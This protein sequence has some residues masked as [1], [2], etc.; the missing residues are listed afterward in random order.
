[1]LE[2]VI[3]R[4]GSLRATLCCALKHFCVG[5]C[6]TNT[7]CRPAAA[8][9][10]DLLS[11]LSL[12]PPL[13][14]YSSHGSSSRTHLG[15]GNRW[16]HRR[17]AARSSW[18]ATHPRRAR[19]VSPDRRPNSRHQRNRQEAHRKVGDGEVDPRSLHGGEGYT[20][21]RHGQPDPRKPARRCWTYQRVRDCSPSTMQ[22]EV[23]VHELDL[24]PLTGSR[25]LEGLP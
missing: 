10:G 19:I 4:R 3:D 25:A 21:R 9:A 5:R 12:S 17:H 13:L 6:W 8:S 7:R 16:S 14:S 18:G 24:A 22:G 2:D 23:Y 15:L 20:H 11:S 1:L